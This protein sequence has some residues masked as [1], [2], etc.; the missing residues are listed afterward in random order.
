MSCCNSFGE[1]QRGCTCPAREAGLIKP[2]RRSL[3]AWVDKCITAALYVVSLAALIS[4]VMLVGAVIGGV[5]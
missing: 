5:V 4:V 3:S 2:L 1:C